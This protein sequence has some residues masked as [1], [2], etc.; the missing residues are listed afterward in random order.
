M[1]I[2]VGDR[3]IVGDL[4]GE[5]AHLEA[6]VSALERLGNGE[7]P[8]EQ[9]LAAAPMLSPFTISRRSSPCLIGGNGGHPTLRGPVIRTSEVWVMAPELRW[10]RT[11]SRLY[12]LGEPMHQEIPQ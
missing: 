6:L 12:R 8:S 5:I 11:Y 7:M 4:A 10:A 2:I 1:P 3:R 9:E